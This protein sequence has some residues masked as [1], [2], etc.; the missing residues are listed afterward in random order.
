MTLLFILLYPLIGV[1]N[2]ECN[3]NRKFD[4]EVCQS[5]NILHAFPIDI[6]ARGSILLRSAQKG[7]P[8]AF[9]PLAKQVVGSLETPRTKY[10]IAKAKNLQMAAHNERPALCNWS[11]PAV[12]R[13][14]G[15][16]S[17]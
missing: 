6:V 9:Y 8:Y 2:F 7:P 15:L 11:R 3:I 17:W 4:S 14:R 13:G 1:V 12:S 5:I 10:S 16:L